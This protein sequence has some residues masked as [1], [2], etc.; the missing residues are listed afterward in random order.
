MFTSPSFTAAFVPPHEANWTYFWTVYEAGDPLSII[1]N[2]TATTTP[3]LTLDEFDL[4]HETTYVVS[5]MVCDDNTPQTCIYL[6]M[7]LE[8]LFNV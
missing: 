7:Y 3:Y 8:H 6:P 2:N 4:N 5:V 1:E